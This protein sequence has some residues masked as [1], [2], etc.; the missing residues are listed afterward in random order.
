MIDTLNENELVVLSALTSPLGCD[1]TEI[2]QCTHLGIDAVSTTLDTLIAK[3]L[4]KDFGTTLRDNQGIGTPN[5]G[6]SELASPLR[7]E[8]VNR[9]RA[10]QKLDIASQLARKLDTSTPDERQGFI[11]KLVDH[12]APN[13]L[14]ALLNDQEPFSDVPTFSEAELATIST[15]EL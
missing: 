7:R 3:G 15:T 8:I 12:I 4:V 5:Y 10:V 9:A 13:I 6:I 1:L 11:M 2:M 14:L